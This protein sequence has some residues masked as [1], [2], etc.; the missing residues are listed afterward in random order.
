MAISFALQIEMPT[1]H[2][3]TFQGSSND[4]SLS[5]LTRGNTIHTRTRPALTLTNG[6]RFLS[7]CTDRFVLVTESR[8]GRVRE[9]RTP[10]PRYAA[11]TLKVGRCPVET[12][13]PYSQGG[14]TPPSSS[15][16]PAI[17]G[18]C[19]RTE[20]SAHLPTLPGFKRVFIFSLFLCP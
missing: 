9:T 5:M 16:D 10:T 7:S 11:C 12:Q 8:Y 4:P 3:G 14:S 17:L 20:P 1:H 13:T 18:L 15:Q 6:T 2:P 19:V